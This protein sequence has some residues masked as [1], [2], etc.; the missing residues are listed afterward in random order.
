M[1]PLTNV[2]EIDFQKYLQV[3]QRR[4]LPAIGIFGV[5][6][7]AA[8]MYAFSLKPIYKAEST[9]LINKTNNTASLTGLGENFGRIETLTIEG[10]PL[11]TQSKIL[12][13]VPV[14]Q[15]AVKA[16][17]LRDDKGKPL[18][19]KDLANQLKV[20]AAKGTDI[21]Q[22]SYT[23]DDPKKVAKL[24]NTVVDIYIAKNIEENQTEAVVARK[25]ISKQLP[26]SENA[27][28]K[29][30]LDLRNFKEK[31]NVLVLQQEASNA[32][33][34]ISKLE[35]EI[36][37][38]EGE[39]AEVTAQVQKLRFQTREVDSQQAIASAELSQVKGTQDVLAQLQSLE[40]QLKLERTRLQPEHPTIIDLEEK[41]TALN[42]LL[43]QRSN[44]VTATTNTLPVGNFQL[45]QLRQKLIAELVEQEN[46]RIAI[47]KK[48]AKLSQE[49]LNYQ[50]RAR[51]LPKLEQ[52]QRELERKLKA[53]Q[54][55]YET[56]LTKY[57]EV[58]VAE[59]QKIGN[60]RIV[61]RA[62]VPTTPDGPQKKMILGGAI[63]FGI[64]LGLITA[65]G[66][67]LIDRSIKTVK[68]ARDLFKY[69]LLGVIPNVTKKS[70]NGRLPE[71]VDSSIP[72]VTAEINQFPLGDAYQMLQANLKYLGSDKQLKA[73]VVTSSVSK[74]GKSEVAANLALAM[75][76]VGRRVLLVDADMR[77]PVQHH[78][79]NLTNAVGLSNLIV[80]QHPINAVVKEIMPYLFVL[81]SG[82]V[83]PNPIALL[84]SKRMTALVSSFTQEYDFVIFDTPPLAG[85]ADAT[86]LS[87]LVD[88][89]LLV[90]RPGVIDY[91]SANAAKEFLNQS[92]QN[93][94]G[95]VINGVN[96]RREPDSYF[97]YKKE[98]IEQYKQNNM[99]RASV[100]AKRNSSGR[101]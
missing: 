89:T 93:V 92:G 37:K 9:I 95:M 15:E 72:I 70:K 78:I 46:K 29:A 71:M 41:V 56:L 6:V 32:V 21:L 39:L 53:A 55:T 4:W 30:E 64:L 34:V 54:T 62:L 84:D 1:E 87:N 24:V 66:L 57:Q 76:Q 5:V 74:E 31:N 86:V 45:G 7:T 97:Y 82:V 67:D 8:S 75:A 20:N 28:R 44:Q 69:T 13:S 38:S 77:R 65:F 58:N 90:V 94:L 43:N 33:N 99:S 18:G 98:S 85:M 51:I 91:G 3:L 27:V 36:T 17:N 80:D 14:M 79:W 63:G 47:E 11:E 49:K 68:E 50:Q 60:A 48:I 83:P 26:A 96:V 59:N 42:S 88:G 101:S 22:V 10:N 61:S 73:I 12:T 40:S 25:F 52:T 23:G 100:L 35:E 81:P 19:P 16:L 2:E